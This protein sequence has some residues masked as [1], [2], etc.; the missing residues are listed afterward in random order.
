MVRQ[1]LI[2]KID[3]VVI[4]MKNIISLS[5]DDSAGFKSD[6]INIIAMPDF[7][8]PASY[9]KVEVI[10][11]SFINDK[12]KDELNCGWFHIQTI[13]RSNN[14]SLSFTA[15]GIA[16]NEKQ[17]EKIS[18]HYNN[19]KLSSVIN[20][21]GDRLGHEVKF[22]TK[23]VLIKSLNQTNESDLNFLERISNL[24]NVL[25]SIKNDIIYFVNK[26]DPSLPISRIDI[27]KCST[28]S[29]KH[30]SKTYYKSCEASFRNIDE[31]KIITI[32]VGEGKPTIKIQNA[33]K[34]K[35]EA[36]I[37]AEAKLNSINKGIVK[38]SLGLIGQTIYAGAKTELFNTY[39][40]EDD[41]IYSVESV[42]HSWSLSTGW[43]TSVE[44]EN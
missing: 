26:D 7:K 22:Q 31:S 23:D 11:R 12:L 4:D 9:S 8:R 40:K 28:S 43:T 16:F 29:I 32:R 13:N 30:S 20:I 3:G 34:D 17:K 33:F 39:N 27:S 1:D 44:I 6:K 35:E 5:F 2:L 19:T 14:K 37:K 36:K 41:G 10:F 18:K 15:T 21:V 25:F 38:G 24:Y 42:K